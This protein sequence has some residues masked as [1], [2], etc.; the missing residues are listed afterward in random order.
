M[1]IARVVERRKGRAV[2]DGGG[3]DQ[4]ES[5]EFRIRHML[6]DIVTRS[7]RAS[8]WRALR[9][10]TAWAYKDS[11]DANQNDPRILQK[12]L[13][14]KTVD[15]RHFI[16]DRVLHDAGIE[17]GHRP[18][19]AEVKV[20]RWTYVLLDCGGFRA[21]QSYMREP[22]GV[23]KPAKFRKGLAAANQFLRQSEM[24]EL[25]PVT[26][27]ETPVYN[28]I[29]IHG[30][31]S[32]NPNKPEF[33]E[34]G[35][36]QLKFAYDDYLAWAATFQLDELIDGCESQGNGPVNGDLPSGGIGPTP[37]WKVQP[38]KKE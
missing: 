34:N 37:T 20:N 32:R 38:K 17:N 10:K 15:D 29:I 9:S 5:E 1:L 30:P 14:P 31:L 33:R 26:S 19:P 28:G 21:T 18:L 27:Q 12:H 35:F 3:A 24:F 7:T 2:A 23:P 11:F 22:G 4:A 13:G 36:I 16:M 25:P 8:L 6:F